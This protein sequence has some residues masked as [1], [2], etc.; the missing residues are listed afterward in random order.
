MN[1][2]KIG[3][4]KEFLALKYLTDMGYKIIKRNYR[5]KMGEIDLIAKKDNRIIFIEVKYRST[6]K[7]GNS[8]EAVTY[9]KRQTIRNVAKHYLLNYYH[10]LDIPISFDVIGIDKQNITHIKNGF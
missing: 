8:I 10:T 2:R 1:Q 3:T 4:D 9:K 6:S 7:Y 5:C